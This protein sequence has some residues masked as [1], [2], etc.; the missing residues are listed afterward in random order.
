LLLVGIPWIVWASANPE[1]EERA[2]RRQKIQ[3]M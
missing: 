1:P 2:Q 3:N